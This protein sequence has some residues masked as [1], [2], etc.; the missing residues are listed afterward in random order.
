M[1]SQKATSKTKITTLSFFFFFFNAVIAAMVVVAFFLVPRNSRSTSEGPTPPPSQ[2]PDQVGAQE[3]SIN[4]NEAA[5][6]TS[7][8]EPT[9]SHRN[10]V[11]DN[12]NN[13]E[14][15]IDSARPDDGSPGAETIPTNDASRP[16]VEMVEEAA[17]GPT[18]R[19]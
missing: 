3:E 6:G 4:R 13:G 1:H 14:R 16:G 2:P 7:L 12:S 9:P 5:P 8:S 11:C 18:T 19:T 10:G 15:G 17:H